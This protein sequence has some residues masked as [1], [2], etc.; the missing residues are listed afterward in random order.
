MTSTTN[1]RKIL[2][3]LAT[4]LAAGAV[5]V[6]SGATFTSTSVSS[7]AVTAGTLVHTNSHDGVSMNV[8]NI[9]PGDSISGTVTIS[10]TGS[11]DSTLTLQETAD[12][13]AFTA[14]DLKLVIAQGSTELYNGNFGALDNSTLLDLG[15]LNTT[16]STT[17]KFTVSMPSG[18]G[19]ANQGK[20][21]SASYRWVTTQS[22]TSSPTLSWG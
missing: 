1:R 2:I 8:A 15:A 19:D 12:N 4:L 9:K 3:P 20:Q 14:G 6:G 21:A 22:G 7:S 10:N 11:L 17:I 18:A 5:A 13:S 16:Q